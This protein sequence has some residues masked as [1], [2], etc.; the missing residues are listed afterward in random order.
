MK[1][2]MQKYSLDDRNS[3]AGTIAVNQKAT[4]G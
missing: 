4:I 3:G 2:D 1:T